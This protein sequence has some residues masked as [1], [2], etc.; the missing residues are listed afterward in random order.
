MSDVQNTHHYTSN[1]DDTIKATLV[2]GGMDIDCGSY[3]KENLGNAFKDGSVKVS[4]VT[5]PLQH[6]FGVLINL[7]LFDD[8]ASQPYRQINATA[9]N[10]PAH[11]ALALDAAQQGMTLLKNVGASKGLPFDSSSIKSIALIGPNA[12]A[13]S[14][15]QGN[16]YGT[17]PYLVSPYEGFGKLTTVNYEQG[18]DI[19]GSSTSGFD[20]A[21]GAAKQSD[22]VVMVMGLDES[23]E[24]EG[25]DRTI[26]TLPGVQEQLITTVAQAAAGKPV[27]V[28]LLGGG[29][30]DM[31][32]AKTSD[33]ISAIMWAGYPG[34]SGG[35]AIARTVFGLSVP[36]GR[37][38]QTM[39]PGSFA[40]NVSMFTQNMR[41]DPSTG[42]PGRSYRFYTGE[43]VYPFGWGLSY[44]TFKYSLEGADELQASL[45]SLREFSSAYPTWREAAPMRGDLPSLAA[46]SITVTNTGSVAASDSVL[47]FVTPPNAGKDGNPLKYLVDYEKVFLKP[48]QSQTVHFQLTARD[49]ALFGTDGRRYAPE[50]LGS[51]VV[52]V[53][54]N[55][56][57]FP[58]RYQ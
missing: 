42:Y 16:Y 39:Y 2:N 14:T 26:L 19:S 27:V 3:L 10:T 53:G 8:P 22:A 31:S 24:S 55:E 43:V 20:A 1:P 25:H 58:L 23:Q 5:V 41:P 33:A 52:G 54:E 7:G 11:Q 49:L 30:V 56:A 28:V 46:A 35:D 51:V 50:G 12:N 40:Q 15:L 37:L 21:V 6:Q 13:T 36:S 45:E 18:C 4:D 47:L 29:M 9:V 57:R 34:Q 17:A 44:T 38:A 32:F 48:G